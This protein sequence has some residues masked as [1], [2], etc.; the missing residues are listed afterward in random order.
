[1][2]SD[3]VIRL[4]G[5]IA[6]LLGV[7]VWPVVLVF[8]LLRFGGA[9]RDFLSN[10]GEFSLKA[11]G[12]EASAKRRREEAVAS[13]GAAIAVREPPLCQD[14]VRHQGQPLLV[15]LEG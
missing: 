2:S 15:E 5:A 10:L 7:L 9:L 14:Q 6:Q 11:P 4:L 8:F 13:L 12:V 3:Q 1:V